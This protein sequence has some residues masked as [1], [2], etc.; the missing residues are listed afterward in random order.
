MHAGS[1]ESTKEAKEL[2]TVATL[3]PLLRQCST[4]LLSMLM[5][6]EFDCLT[7][8]QAIAKLCEP[9]SQKNGFP[10]KNMVLEKPESIN[11]FL[12][13]PLPLSML[14]LVSLNVISKSVTTSIRGE[15]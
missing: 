8:L 13:H 14:L 10:C 12:I 6:T 1:L 4:I 5:S 15:G 9:L 2:L 11:T 3:L 7:E